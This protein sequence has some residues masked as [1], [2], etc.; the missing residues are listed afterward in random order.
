MSEM[1][2][3]HQDNTIELPWCIP[4]PLLAPWGT[5]PLARFSLDLLFDDGLEETE[6]L[7]RS[8]M[9]YSDTL[10]LNT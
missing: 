5:T 3:E 1:L 2:L 4:F 7:S 8:P 10:L 9:I 6:T